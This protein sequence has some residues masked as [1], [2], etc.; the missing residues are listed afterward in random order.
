MKQDVYAVWGRSRRE[1]SQDLGDSSTTSSVVEFE[2]RTYEVG[3]GAQRV[4]PAIEV[5]VSLS[6]PGLLGAGPSQIDGLLAH[7]INSGQ[8]PRPGASI[9]GA[10]RLGSLTAEQASE[11]L[12]REGL[13]SGYFPNVAWAMPRL[14]ELFGRGELAPG[15]GHTE[16]AFLACLVGVA[17]G[18]LVQ[19][20]LEPGPDT[21]ADWHRLAPIREKPEPVARAFV[22]RIEALGRAG[23]PPSPASLL[24]YALAALET[25]CHLVL[26]ERWAVGEGTL[27]TARS[28]LT[29]FLSGCE[30]SADGLAR[31]AAT[32]LRIYWEPSLGERELC[33][34]WELA[35]PA[36]AG[37]VPPKPRSL[38]E[39][40]NRDPTER[41]RLWRSASPARRDH[42]PA[43]A[44]RLGEATAEQLEPL[45]D[46]GE[47]TLGSLEELA[48]ALPRMLEL[49]ADG[50]LD[51]SFDFGEACFLKRVV[52]AARGWLSDGS[53]CI[54]PERL[55]ECRHLA[56]MRATPDV[57]ADVFLRRIRCIAL[58]PE[59]SWPSPEALL[60]YVLAAM[61]IGCHSELLAAWAADGDCI[62]LRQALG[63]YLAPT[64][65]DRARLRAL[66]DESFVLWTPTLADEHLRDLWEFLGLAA[67]AD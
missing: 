42:M 58:E 26:F 8:M 24:L 53:E 3:V 49:F 25:G 52:W 51:P 43:P 22:E 62:L 47:T 64:S 5:E 18:W 33:G 7:L 57:M 10:P 13:G 20:G 38:Y 61:E 29:E 44:V 6:G 2:G 17:R 21:L 45:A 63:E 14:I 23:H 67:S 37:I 1:R 36:V 34:L 66:A 32:Q 4:G 31:L 11:L 55:R 48:W 15:C 28:A 65:G 59:G 12:E 46:H 60:R 19:G 54:S 35:V 40:W 16:A 50:S 39:A 56:P 9:A 27:A 41:R 30:R